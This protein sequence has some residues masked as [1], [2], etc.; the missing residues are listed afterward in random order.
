M[1]QGNFKEMRESVRRYVS[2]EVYERTRKRVKGDRS[3]RYFI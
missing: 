3:G 2:G 1:G